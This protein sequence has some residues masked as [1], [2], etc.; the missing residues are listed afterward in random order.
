MNFNFKLPLILFSAA[1]FVCLSDLATLAQEDS[2]LTR[3]VNIHR[4]LADIYA[5]QREFQ[6]ADREYRALTKL[7]P[8]DAETHYN[9]GLFL[10]QCGKLMPALAEMERAVKLDPT[11]ANYESAVQKFRA[12]SKRMKRPNNDLQ[13]QF[14]PGD[15][16]QIRPKRS[17]EEVQQYLDN[18]DR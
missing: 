9:Y 17:M 6:K 15:F 11:E 8:N 7:K 16:L 5:K 18:I 10:A 14:G 13:D 1:Y 2:G 12:L 3:A 4:Y